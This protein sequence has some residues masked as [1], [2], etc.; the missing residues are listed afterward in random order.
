MLEDRLHTLDDIVFS[1]FLPDDWM[2]EFRMYN[3]YSRMSI[4]VL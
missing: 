3:T 1:Y 2:N 4:T